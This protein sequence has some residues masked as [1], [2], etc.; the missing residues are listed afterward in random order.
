MD[1]DKI[2]RA[3]IPTGAEEAAQPVEAQ[4]GIVAI[5][6]GRRAEL[7]FAGVRLQVCDPRFDGRFRREI[8]LCR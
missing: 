2:D 4:I 8:G 7:G 1:G 6:H 3:A 5:T